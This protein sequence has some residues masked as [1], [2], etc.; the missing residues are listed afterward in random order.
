MK[1]FITHMGLNSYLEMSHAGVPAVAIPIFVDQFYNSG[2]AVKNGVAVRLCKL[3][4]SRETL[5]NALK[6]VL[7]NPRYTIILNSRLD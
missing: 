4:L 2:C 7:N 5:T 6:E 1:V 3:E